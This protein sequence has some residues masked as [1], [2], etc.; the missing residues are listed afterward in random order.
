LTGLNEWLNLSKPIPRRPVQDAGEIRAKLRR[1]RADR[2]ATAQL[3]CDPPNGEWIGYQLVEE[4][5]RARRDESPAPTTNAI[6]G[7]RASGHAGPGNSHL[8]Q[9]FSVASRV[10]SI[11]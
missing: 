10:C 2:G 1:T 5:D 3:G 4:T 8:T 6:I 11:S 7:K 9:A